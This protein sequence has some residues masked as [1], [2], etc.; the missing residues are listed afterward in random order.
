MSRERKQGWSGEG[1][2]IGGSGEGSRGRREDGKGIEN[3]R[4]NDSLVHAQTRQI[5]W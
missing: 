5:I 4:E 3:R 1:R 2:G